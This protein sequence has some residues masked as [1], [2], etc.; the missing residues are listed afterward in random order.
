MKFGPDTRRAL[1][2]LAYVIAVV[3]VLYVIFGFLLLNSWQ[4]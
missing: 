3:L 4:D 1:K 2:T